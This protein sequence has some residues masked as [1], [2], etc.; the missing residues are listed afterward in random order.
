MMSKKQQRVKMLVQL[1]NSLA[2]ISNDSE[3]QSAKDIRINMQ[4]LR[5]HVKAILKL[6]GISALTNKGKE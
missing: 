5:D 1:D 4:I 2:D 6:D 3:G